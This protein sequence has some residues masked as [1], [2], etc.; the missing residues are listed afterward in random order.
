M[1]ADRAVMAAEAADDPLRIA[2]AKW[3]LGQIL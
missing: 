1:V 2:A 3:N